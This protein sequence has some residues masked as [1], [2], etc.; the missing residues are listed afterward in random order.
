MS[1]QEWPLRARRARA[2]RDCS[3][4][5]APDITTLHVW[6][7]TK[8]TLFATGQT[9]VRAL[10]CSIAP[11]A[12]YPGPAAS[13]QTGSMPAADCLLRSRPE[14]RLRN[15]DVAWRASCPL[16]F[17]CSFSCSTCKRRDR[18]GQHLHGEKARIGESAHFFLQAP[19]H[20]IRCGQAWASS[21]SP[22]RLVGPFPSHVITDRG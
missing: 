18:R 8:R 16:T 13:V 22:A 6:L 14:S 20:P 11:K 1:P 10:L 17:S 12:I 2:G 19:A 9:N 3:Q 15:S 4:A 21:E 7:T 5:G